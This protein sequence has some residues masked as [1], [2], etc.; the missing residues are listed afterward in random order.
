MKAAVVNGQKAS[1]GPP[2]T[3]LPPG[4]SVDPVEAAG[5]GRDQL[6]AVY[7]CMLLSRK[8]DDKE[9]QLK[10][11][12]RIF[13]QIS[14]AG[15]EAVQVAAGL[16]LTA[17]YDWFYPYYR[18]RALCLQLG[19]T[20][21]L[22]GALAYGR[23]GLCPAL[24]KLDQKVCPAGQD[25]GVLKLVQEPERFGQSLGRVECDVGL[26]VERQCYFSPGPDVKCLSPLSG[27][28]PPC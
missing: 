3:I 26:P 2:D 6:I 28:P 24:S 16:T 4:Q 17:G 22:T 23:P 15:H 9:I 7:R 18:D 14:G 21:L 1:A 20:P 8:L 13:F 12:S 5:L 25:P 27:R 19:L 10:H 11:Q